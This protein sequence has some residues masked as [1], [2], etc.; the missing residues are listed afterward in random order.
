MTFSCTLISTS[1]DSKLV[2]NKKERERMKH[3]RVL[4]EKVRTIIIMIGYRVRA[5]NVG[6][7]HFFAILTL[8]AHA[9]PCISTG[10]GVPT[11]TSKSPKHPPLSLSKQ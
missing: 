7:N 4:L 3:K 8:L 2:K 9:F 10:P 11:L 1:V 5:Q 6:Q